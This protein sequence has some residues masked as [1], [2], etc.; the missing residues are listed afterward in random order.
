VCA[1]VCVCVC[2]CVCMR[3]CMYVYVFTCV[4]VCVCVCVCIYI[5]LPVI[6]INQK[7]R[8]FA[9]GT[10]ANLVPVFSLA[11]TLVFTLVFSL[12][13]SEGPEANLVADSKFCSKE[14]NY[15]VKRD[16]LQCQKRPTTVSKETYYSEI[17]GKKFATCPR[18]Y[19]QMW[20]AARRACV[21]GFSLGLS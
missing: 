2:V 6:V 13:F 12:V 15:S 1:C 5:Y 14:T 20:D 4:C 9:R 11:F 19:A 7:Q 16:L 17:K 18:F 8:S 10:E 21:L 3:V